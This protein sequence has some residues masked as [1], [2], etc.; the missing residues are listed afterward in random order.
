MGSTINRTVLVQTV[1]KPRTRTQVGWLTDGSQPEDHDLDR[2]GIDRSD[3]M[4]MGWK[5]LGLGRPPCFLIEVAAPW[6]LK[7]TPVV[8]R[9][10]LRQLENL[11]KRWAEIAN[12]GEAAPT[13]TMLRVIVR[14][15]LTIKQN[16]KFLKLTRDYLAT[17]D[18][19]ATKTQLNQIIDTLL[20]THGKT[21]TRSQ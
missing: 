7:V 10:D 4:A 6:P 11:A 16:R 5:R 12:D 13:G 19:N 9:H 18:D 8:T 14:L 1:D 3:I 20:G 2:W 17:L 15:L 21:R